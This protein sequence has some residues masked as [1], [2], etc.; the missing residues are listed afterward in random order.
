[1]TGFWRTWMAGWCWAVAVFGLV[2]TG[3][4]FEATSGPIRLLFSVLNSQLVLDL[5]A[6][7]RFSLALMGA[8]TLGWGL[9]FRVIL[10]ATDGLSKSQA[11]PVWR[12]TTLA[13]LVWFVV[14]STLSVTTGFAPNAASNLLL[15]VGYL[16]PLLRTGALKA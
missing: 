14:D 11:A 10:S 12:Q 15:V 16:L 1:M 5:N 8:V 13:V 2:L 7:L 6:P 4:A 9:T 3:A